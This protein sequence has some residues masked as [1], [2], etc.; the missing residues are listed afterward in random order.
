MPERVTQTDHNQEPGTAVE[1]AKQEQALELETARTGEPPENA[2]DATHSIIWTPRFLLAFALLLVVG[3]SADSL[4]ASGWST[5]LFA[6]MGQWFLL[7]HII[8]AAGGWLMLGIL[9]RSRW[10]RLSCV[11]GGVCAVFLVLTLFTTLAG[12]DPASPSQAYINVA[13]CTALLGAYIG[14]S[15]EGTLLS[16][17]D[18]WLFLLLPILGAIGVTLTYVLTPQASIITTENAVAATT[19]IAA[20]LVWWARPSC[21]KRAPGP[22]FLFGVV[23]LLQL[24]MAMLN[25]SLHNFFFLQAL[26]PHISTNANLSNFF[27]GEFILLCLFLGC[28]RLAKSE[29]RN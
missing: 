20:C 14:L 10:I 5:G 9:T 23:P 16:A 17:W 19:V 28:M 2:P 26:A 27:F 4:L 13:A 15:I 18:Y 22:T 29:I 6:G 12:V 21:W 1:G 3:T 7:G 24:L 25:N 8:L 11:F